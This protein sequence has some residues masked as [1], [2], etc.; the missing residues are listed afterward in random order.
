MI[1]NY[2]KL[3]CAVISLALYDLKAA[4]TNKQSNPDIESAMWFIS[5]RHCEEWC[6][7]VGF[8]YEKLLEASGRYYRRYLETEKGRCYW[9][10]NARK[11]A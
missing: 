7:E 9:N 3:L 5:G 11:M 10:Y 6:L 4:G 8:N 1:K 2:H